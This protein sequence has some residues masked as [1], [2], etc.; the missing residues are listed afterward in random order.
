MSLN[1]ECRA[2][3]T[4]GKKPYDHVMFS[5]SF[6]KEVDRAFDMQVVDL[7][8]TMEAFWNLP[9]PYPGNPYDHNEFRKYY[10]DHHL[11]VFRMNTALRDDDG[12]VSV[13]RRESPSDV[14]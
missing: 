13:T 3:N 9:T 12:V 8:P 1:D 7:V 4:I 10:S 14:Q 2:T 5:P 11:V 6:T